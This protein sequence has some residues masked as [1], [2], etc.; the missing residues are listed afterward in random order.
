LLGKAHTFVHPHIDLILWYVPTIPLGFA[1][2][3]VA[4][5]QAAEHRALWRGDAARSF[6]TALVPP[7]I[8]GAAVAIYF[9][10]RTIETQ[11][12]WAISS[13][14]DA[15]PIFKSTELGADFRMNDQWFIIQYE[16]PIVRSGETFFIRADQGNAEVSYDF[17]LRQRQVFARK[18]KCISA[19]AKT[20][21]RFSKIRYG[22]DVRT[23]GYL[24]ARNP[25]QIS[26]Y[27]HAGAANQRRLGPRHLP[28]LRNRAHG[29]D[30]E[31]C[32]PLHSGWRPCRVLIRSAH[33]QGIS[34]Y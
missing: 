13:Y 30:R 28:H 27:L 11:G 26:R 9:A 2:V 21:R 16:S 1:M 23:E 22:P 33:D 25:I 31:F 4:S 18:G 5:A 19:Q 24:A 15:T 34:S 6:V 8:L 3:A 32:R 17:A 20:D 7:V 10:D 29:A 14:A 12:T